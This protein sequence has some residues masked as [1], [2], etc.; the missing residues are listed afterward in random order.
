M[1]KVAILDDYQ[2]VSQDFVD[3]KQLS[4]KYE[5][6]DSCEGMTGGWCKWDP[7]DT[8]RS[9]KNV[10][11]TKTT[12][13]DCIGVGINKCKWDD[14]SSTCSIIDCQTNMGKT[15]GQFCNDECFPSTCNDSSCSMNVSNVDEPTSIMCS[16]ATKSS[17][18]ELRRYR[19]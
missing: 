4:G 8:E 1:L 6:Y 19:R 3:L 16:R 17:P 2:N 11:E 13:A 7:S 18:R 12:G 15:T 5:D 9:C 10:C 14:A